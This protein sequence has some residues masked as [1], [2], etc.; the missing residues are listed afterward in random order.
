MFKYEYQGNILCFLSPFFLRCK[1]GFEAITKQKTFTYV[2]GI[3]KG[4]F[5]Q[6]KVLVIFY[7]ITGY[8]IM[9]TI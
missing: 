8:S 4:E 9:P 5:G 2:P 7:A 3:S 6:D 1:Q